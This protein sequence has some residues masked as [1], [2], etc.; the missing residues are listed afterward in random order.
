MNNCKQMSQCPAKMSD[1]RHGTDYRSPCEIHAML[2]QQNNIS[3]QHDLRMLLQRQGHEL[4][5][6]RNKHM[7]KHYGCPQPYYHIDIN[8]NDKKNR[9]RRN[10][11]IELY[12]G[13]K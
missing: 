7:N 13:K 3:N 6:L 9:Q 5:A 2:Q 11:L 12:Y 1:G 10:Q 8:Y 4:L